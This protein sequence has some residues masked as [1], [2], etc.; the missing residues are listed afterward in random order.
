MTII[1]TISRNEKRILSSFDICA[2]PRFIAYLDVTSVILRNT[3]YAYF[4]IH[5][6]NPQYEFRDA[7]DLREGFR[8]RAAGVWTPRRGCVA[9]AG[10]AR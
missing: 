7:R 1:V 10:F 4:I 2:A 9:L 5:R 8:L 3:R 6:G